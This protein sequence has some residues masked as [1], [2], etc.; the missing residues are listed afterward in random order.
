MSVD[1]I[2]R[3]EM[4]DCYLYCLVLP[5]QSIFVLHFQLLFFLYAI[6]FSSLLSLLCLFSKPS[7]H[8]ALL[9]SPN[10]LSPGS[11]QPRDVTPS[12]SPTHSVQYPIA[13]H[14]EYMH[15]LV[16]VPGTMYP[17]MGM[18]L[19]AGLTSTRSRAGRAAQEHLHTCMYIHMYIHSD[20][21]SLA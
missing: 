15:I 3:L 20:T 21:G 1:L 11:R 2:P 19:D 6:Y 14:R 10:Q 18:H 7:S 16:A 8:C 5:A 13:M 17:Y 9:E 4:C 12:H